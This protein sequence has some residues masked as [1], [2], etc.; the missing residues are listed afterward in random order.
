M[1]VS[2]IFLCGLCCP[3]FI[4]SLPLSIFTE[5]LKSVHHVATLYPVALPAQQDGGWRRVVLLKGYLLLQDKRWQIS[6]SRV[7]SRVK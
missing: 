6:P 2:N 7:L 3:S 4:L 5:A 1:A